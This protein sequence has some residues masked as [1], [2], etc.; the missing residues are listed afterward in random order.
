MLNLIF[1]VRVHIKIYSKHCITA[2]FLWRAETP[3]THQTLARHILIED[4][5]VPTHINLHE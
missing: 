5:K 1:T 4:I 2:R 3:D